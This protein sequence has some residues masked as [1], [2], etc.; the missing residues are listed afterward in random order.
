M[1]LF[2]AFVSLLRF[3]FRIIGWVLENW[4]ILAVISVL[5]NA[6]V[7]PF[8][9][10]IVLTDSVN[11]LAQAIGVVI[12]RFSDS[13]P[14]IVTMADLRGWI[15]EAAIWL[16]TNAK[17][18]NILQAAQ[19]VCVC[20][21]VAKQVKAPRLYLPE[22][23][24]PG[25]SFVRAEVLPTFQASV[26]ELVEGAWREIGQCF[27]LE[28]AVVTARHVVK[29]DAGRVR[30]QSGRG[31][32][33]IEAGRFEEVD[34]HTDLAYAVLDE[35]EW[36]RLGLAKAKLH[37]AAANGEQVLFVSAQTSVEKTSGCLSLA[38]NLFGFVR[39]TG[40]TR[41]GF[42]GA[43]Y[44][45]GNK[46]YGMHLGASSEN[47][48]YDAGYILMKLRGLTESS[49][50]YFEKLVDNAR[51]RG[52]K[53]VVR[54]TGDPDVVEV[55][56]KGHYVRLDRDLL[57]GYGDEVESATYSQESASQGNGKGP[58]ADA[59]G[60]GQK[61]SPVPAPVPSGQSS[62]STPK[63]PQAATEERGTESPAST[64]V[65]SSS[66][67]PTMSASVKPRVLLDQQGRLSKDVLT[68]LSKL[69][70][71]GGSG[72]NSAELKLLRQY[73]S[74]TLPQHPVIVSSA[75]TAQQTV[76]S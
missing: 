44:A 2:Q 65:P 70:A 5:I 39:Y 56:V 47:I 52:R 67:S 53:L 21:M 35:K 73:A 27:R 26:M 19:S 68:V 12:S 64:P 25:S 1:S 11:V 14:N 7:I 23:A 71:N 72:L 34:E 55:F 17:D 58:R 31:M 37:P 66:R 36:A 42:S 29:E 9:A 54:N 4:Q 38:T 3:P 50:D 20:V 49:T 59:R 51:R 63:Q 74:S 48:G 22:K 69:S 16:F 60:P 57:E 18:I 40:S 62:P 33:E 13:S 43:P 41:A 30:L 10:Y 8:L 76:P 24:M 75:A 61:T 6:T 15:D 28:M 32:L 45:M 46:V